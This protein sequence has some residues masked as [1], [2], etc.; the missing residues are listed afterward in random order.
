MK[1]SFI[2]LSI[3]SACALA[4]ASDPAIEEIKVP[5]DV[6]KLEQ[7]AVTGVKFSV[8]VP[9]KEAYEM[10]SKFKANSEGLAVLTVSLHSK[11]L[12]KNSKKM[13]LVLSSED[14]LEELELNEYNRFDLPIN[15]LAAEQDAKFKLARL[16]KGA[17]L[18]YNVSSRPTAAI[19]NLTYGT[20]KKSLDVDYKSFKS[21]MPW[22]VVAYNAITKNGDDYFSICHKEKGLPVIVK[23][24]DVVLK[25]LETMTEE[26]E[27]NGAVLYCANF[28][29]KEQ[30]PLLAKIQS[31]AGAEL[32]FTGE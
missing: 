9:Y 22:Y 27:K 3:L 25:K 32:R 11:S 2:F 24:G 31:P 26:K 4:N 15:K 28:N 5:E 17:T 16:P 30:L 7:I 23:D 19:E 13:R 12:D 18:H 8:G 29:G 20:I 21:I 10:A 14:V 1:R 6:I